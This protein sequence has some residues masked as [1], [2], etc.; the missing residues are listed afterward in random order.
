MVCEIFPAF[1][2]RLEGRAARANPTLD[3]SSTPCGKLQRF[4]L[5]LKECFQS[6]NTGLSGAYQFVGHASPPNLA[7]DQGVCKI[8]DVQEGNENR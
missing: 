2:I 5:Q 4:S 7:R 8:H 6:D 3:D 1:P